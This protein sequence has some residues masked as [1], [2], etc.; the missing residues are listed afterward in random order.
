MDNVSEMK[1]PSAQGSNSTTGFK[2]RFKLSALEI[3]FGIL[4]LLGVIYIGYF[5]LFQESSGA[6][7]K[8]Q[9]KINV[10]E[11]SSREQ[12][13]KVNRSLKAIQE[14]EAQLEGRL[15][16]QEALNRD[17][18]A[19]VGKME[20]RLAGETKPTPPKEKIHYR[21][22][23]GET[24]QT[25]AKKFKVSADDLARWN[26]LDKNRPVRPGDSLVLPLR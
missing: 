24:L 1:D 17:L 16:S 2:Q 6:V 3:L 19:K 4:I 10:M 12:A 5:I 18:L 20:K 23:K 14:N 26:K 13:E 7:S 11:T 15:K 25:I 22:K 8:L 21:V 9:K